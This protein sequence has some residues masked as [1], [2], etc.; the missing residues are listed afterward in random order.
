MLC[1]P[2]PRRRSRASAGASARPARSRRR[3]APG[4]SS[5]ARRV[6][7][8]RRRSESPRRRAPRPP[9]SGGPATSCCHACKVETALRGPGRARVEPGDLAAPADCAEE[10]RQPDRDL[11][12]VPLGRGHR[13]G[14]VAAGT[15]RAPRGTGPG[16]P[17][18]GEQQVARAAG[19]DQRGPLEVRHVAVLGRDLG[20]AH[21][22]LPRARAAAA[23]PGHRPGQPGRPGRPAGGGAG[24]RGCGGARHEPAQAGTAARLRA[25]GRFACAPPARSACAPPAR[26]LRAPA[27]RPAPPA[28]PF[29]GSRSPAPPPARPGCRPAAAAGRGAGPDRRG[30][31]PP[32]A[33]RSCCR[34]RGRSAR[35]RSS[36]PSAS[37]RPH[38][39]HASR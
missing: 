24:R 34:T 12:R 6:V 33:R 13:P 1:R 23:G 3:S 37:E 30:P 36:V 16:R 2:R 38:A 18:M 15:G 5:R 11:Q 22:A 20:R 39:A 31:G 19:A 28:R 26:W 4:S 17:A 35:S 10:E 21:L 7:A 32:A 27:L 9:A 25:S 8:R 29:M 14:R